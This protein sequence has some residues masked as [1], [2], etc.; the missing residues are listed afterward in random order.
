MRACLRECCKG[1][2]QKHREHDY[3]NIFHVQASNTP[4]ELK[5]HAEYHMKGERKAAYMA[6]A[7]HPHSK[8]AVYGNSSDLIVMSPPTSY[9][10]MSLTVS[11]PVLPSGQLVERLSQTPQRVERAVAG[12][13]EPRPNRAATGRA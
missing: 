7:K 13:G 11:Y 5:A 1:K 12:F 9:C 6:Q 3:H 4:I 10:S 2:D 8:K